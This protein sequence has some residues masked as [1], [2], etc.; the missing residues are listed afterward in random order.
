MTE[1][2][3]GRIA[4]LGA[5]CEAAL[6]NERFALQDDDLEQAAICADLAERFSL[7]A[8]EVAQA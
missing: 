2:Q 6:I 4:R 8:F 1:D 7:V 3:K 5:D